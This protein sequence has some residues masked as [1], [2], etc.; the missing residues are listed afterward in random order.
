MMGLR[1]NWREPQRTLLHGPVRVP[2][3]VSVLV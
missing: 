1:M 2:S 3:I